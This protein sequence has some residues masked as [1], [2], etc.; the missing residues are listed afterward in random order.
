MVDH[1]RHDSL[2]AKSCWLV[3]KN[4]SIFNYLFDDCF[5][6]FDVSHFSVSFSHFAHPVVAIS[7]SWPGLSRYGCWPPCIKDPSRIKDIMYRMGRNP[8]AG[9]LLMICLVL[10]FFLRFF[11]SSFSSLVFLFVDIS[12]SALLMNFTQN[13]IDAKVSH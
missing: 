4:T 7:N 9:S 12:C 6:S 2:I 8:D 11:S 1:Y 10:V 5:C 13:S 3:A